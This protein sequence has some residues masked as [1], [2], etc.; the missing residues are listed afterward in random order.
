MTHVPRPLPLIA[1]GLALAL[2]VA[3]PALAHAV[4]RSADPA[5]GSTVT[6]PPQ[7]LTLTYSETLEARFCRVEVTDAAGASMT[8]GAAH[9]DP[10]DAKRLVVALKPLKPGVYAV[11]WHAT[12]TDTHRT[13][14]HFR[15]T[16]AP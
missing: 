6:Q 13:Q 1:A 16:V 11:I 14:G 2:G 9:G 8:A 4:L 12:A 15:F 3:S 7:Q 5:S 10:S